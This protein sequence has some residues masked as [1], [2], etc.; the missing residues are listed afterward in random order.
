MIIRIKRKTLEQA[1]LSVIL[2]LTIVSVLVG[3]TFTTNYVTGE[4]TN[5]TN[6]TV[7]AKLNVTNTEPN[8]TA[9]KMDDD[10]SSPEDIIDLTA[11][12]VTIVSCN[13]TVFDYNG[14][15]DIDADSVNATIFIDNGN[16]N[17]NSP[18]D[19]NTHYTNRS[20]G[21]CVQGAS[22]TEAICD[23]RF[24]VQ[25]YANNSVW[26][27]N[28]SVTD[29]GGTGKGTPGQDYLNFTDSE[30][31]NATITKLLAID[32]PTTIL[33]YGN[34]SVTEISAAIVRNI[35]NVGNINLNLTLRGF[36]GENDSVTNDNYTMICTYGNIT[37]GNHRYVVGSNVTFDNMVNL[38]NQTVDTNFTLPQRTNDSNYGQD[39]NQTFWRL[40]IPLT[41]G[42]LCNG[43]IIF[44][45]IEAT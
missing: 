15:Q 30:T 29:R 12:S 33:D 37:F 40:Q 8:I 9:V 1:I 34:L 38:T 2:L 36:G 5:I 16:D 26:K 13:A 28:I 21:R 10:V 14:W 19:N 35:T 42:G 4:L 22:P 20:C 32:T 24:A 25:Y 3:V 23:C 17:I 45:A 18:D 41:V 31:D 44:G 6:I 7:V 39:R 43:T 27:C 11:N